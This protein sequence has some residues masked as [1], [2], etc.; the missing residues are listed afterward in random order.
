M[1]SR[2][3]QGSDS[4]SPGYFI[5]SDSDDTTDG[6]RDAHDF[7]DLPASDV[8]AELAASLGQVPRDDVDATWDETSK[9][10]GRRNFEF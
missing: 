7:Y 4:S 1:D 9:I 10:K 8:K 6:E 3:A 5:Y 2:T